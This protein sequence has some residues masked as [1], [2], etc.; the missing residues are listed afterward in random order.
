MRVQFWLLGV[1]GMIVGFRR[2]V[3]LAAAALLL[4]VVPAGAASGTDEVTNTG[5]ATAT[6]VASLPFGASADYSGSVPAPVVDA[7][8]SAVGQAC[9]AG[10]PVYFPQWFRYQAPEDVTVI[11]R[12]NWVHHWTVT[13]PRPEAIAL[14]A[15]DGLTVLAC[16][17]APSRGMNQVGPLQLAAG[18]AAYVVRY[19]ATL[20]EAESLADSMMAVYVRIQASTGLVPANDSPATPQV[21]SDLPVQ[22]SQ[23]ISLATTT[24]AED[25]LIRRTSCYTTG[26]E[27]PPGPSVWYEYAA[28]A[29]AR[30]AVD[31]SASDFPVQLYIGELSDAGP[32][33]PICKEWGGRHVVELVAGTRYLIGFNGFGHHLDLAGQ[34]QMSIAGRPDPPVAVT[35]VPGSEQVTVSWSPGPSDGG[36]PV[37]GYRVTSHPDEVGCATTGALSC[38]VTGLP[39]GTDYT[40]T[41]T[42]TNSVETSAPSAPSVSVTPRGTPD[43]PTAVTATPANR[44]ATVSWSPPPRDGGAAI[45]GYTV[46]AAPGGLGCTTLGATTC[47]VTGL[48]NGTAYTFVV[49]AQNALGFSPASQPS[50]AVTPNT[51]PGAV[52][53]VLAVPDDRSVTVSWDPA[54]S[55]GTPVTGYVATASPGGATCQTATATCRIQGL[56][57]GTAY[58]F[59][60]IASNSMGAGPPSPPTAPVTPRTRPGAPTSV[61]AVAGDARATV[62]WAP[63]TTSGG[64]PI[65]A[66]AVT[67]APGGFTCQ[68]GGAEN[69]C[70]VVGL[71]NGT[72]YT[73]VVAAINEAGPSVASVPSNSVTPAGPPGPP[74]ELLVSGSQL[75]PTGVETRLSWRTP[76]DSG[77]GSILG[78]TITLSD[79]RTWATG[80]QTLL[81]IGG[82]TP[83][84]FYT[85]T[86]SARSAGGQSPPSEALGFVAAAS[87]LPPTVKVSARNNS[88]K[89]FIDV[90]PDKGTGFWTFQVQR[91]QADGTWK[92]LK[93]YRTKGPKETRTI[94]LRKGTYRVWVKAKYGLGSALSVQVKLRK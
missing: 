49:S 42:A 10:A 9:N 17:Q 30:I 93:S 44:S 94:G 60:V 25:Q 40:F 75:T 92:P 11:A 46:L 18:Q 16:G 64:A 38:T 13:I 22:V 41:V 24:S 77:G 14:I 54:P 69:S 7:A 70:Q 45:S 67:A 88:S 34:L 39:N 80:P 3:V 21:I 31:W 12:A 4:S 29:T 59:T 65:T 32:I 82:L 58:T 91:K 47:T 57:N 5:P 50:I 73:F 56:A 26:E 62:T 61:A 53:H 90:D 8:N 6:E 36:S 1:T 78:Y 43:A 66:Y 55:E 71:A 63:S 15:A 68:A 74:N 33:N 83:G 51:F 23:D 72:A 2:A 37:T 89:L 52:T 76:Q 85:V 86:V 87:G 35:A 28:P 84:R 20:A 48:A 27:P 81:W 19:A 79:G